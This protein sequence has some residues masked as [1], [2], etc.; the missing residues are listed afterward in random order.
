VGEPEPEIPGGISQQEID[1]AI[2][3]PA[4]PPPELA[5]A[6]PPGPTEQ[7]TPAPAAAAPL[8]SAPSGWQQPAHH[9][10]ANGVGLGAAAPEAITPP[11][12]SAPSAPAPFG[13]APAVAVAPAPAVDAGYQQTAAAVHMAVPTS[14]RRS[15]PNLALVG[16]SVTATPVITRMP[17]RSSPWRSVVVAFFAV[18][19]LAALAVH[20]AFIPLDVLVVWRRPAWLW[21]SSEPPGARVD[22]DGELLPDS[23]PMRV[24]VQRDQREHVVELSQTGWLP[25]RKVVRYDREVTLS[26]TLPMTADPT[27]PKPPEVPPAE[28]TPAVPPP[29]APAPQ[30]ATDTRPAAETAPSGGGRQAS[31]TKRPARHRSAT[32]KHGAR[33]KAAAAKSRAAKRARGKR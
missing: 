6:A 31:A 18:L 30:A 17:R 3:M 28:P 23:T 33:K 15:V 5:A 27:P 12:T 20:L 8:G 4:T 29:A 19:L 1:E 10:H 7:A 24:Q 11:P 13:A 32:G 16:G 25:A 21:I 26:H 2:A 14:G 9:P 22:L